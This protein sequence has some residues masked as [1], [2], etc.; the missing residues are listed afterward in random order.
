MSHRAKI[1]ALAL[2]LLSALLLIPLAASARLVGGEVPLV[3]LTFHQAYPGGVAYNSWH[4]KFAVVWQEKSDFNYY[5]QPSIGWLD[6]GGSTLSRYLLDPSLSDSSIP[7]VDCGG[8]KCLA[9]WVV[10]DKVYARTAT[11]DGPLGSVW[12]V[13]TGQAAETSTVVYGADYQYLIVWQMK[14]GGIAMRNV[15]PLSGPSENVVLVQ[16]PAGCTQPQNVRV[17]YDSE[18]YIYGITYDCHGT[19]YLEGRGAWLLDSRWSHSL[20]PNSAHQY[21]PDIAAREGTFMLVFESTMPAPGVYGQRYDSDGHL[22]STVAIDTASTAQTPRLGYDYDSDEYLVT[23][24]RG[25]V[26]YAARIDQAD[27]SLLG[28]PFAVSPASAGQHSPTV[29]RFVTFGDDKMLVVWAD[30]REGAADADIYGRWIELEPILGG[31]DPIS[32]ELPDGG[33]SYYQAPLQV[34]QW[35]AVGIR[36]SSGGDLDLYLTDGPDYGNVLVSSL[37]GTGMADIVVMD[38][39]QLGPA[40][41]FPYVHHYSG[42]T[43]YDIEYA[44]RA[45]RITLEHS[46]ANQS[47]AAESVARMFDVYA[48][49]GQSL[50]VQVAPG[51][52]DVGLALFDPANGAHQA[53][54]NAVMLA[55]SGGAGQG[56]SLSYF[57]AQDGWLG[58]LVWKKDGAADDFSLSAIGAG[59]P[60]KH[61]IFLPLVVHA[62]TSS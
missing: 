12:R 46:Y 36:P 48:L 2:V 52:S 51:I 45:D 14:D 32:Q 4:S 31:G 41:Y 44:P 49:A 5:Y 43:Y 23:Y 13:D 62:G 28:A 40:A 42:Y 56:E 30:I 60:P 35:Q 8:P 33:S 25:G 19:V 47:L 15:D 54:N 24:N 3:H 38:G 27:G 16:L 26:T 57:P 10:N 61:T 20:P 9:T 1:L 6:P 11:L 7:D 34:G 55:D 21:A 39:Y 50:T 59:S 29:S 18:E 17:T 37:N 53:L 58:L 22:L